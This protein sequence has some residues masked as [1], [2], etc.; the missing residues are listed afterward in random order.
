MLMRAE[1]VDEKMC[2]LERIRVR[3]YTWVRSFDDQ[4]CGW[5]GLGSWPG[6]EA[7]MDDQ[8]CVWLGLGSGSGH[9]APMVSA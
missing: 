5:L 4:T 2:S 6:H 8:T 7:P 3:C 9:D 1:R